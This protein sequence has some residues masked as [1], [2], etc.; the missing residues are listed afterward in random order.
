MR[1]ELD[2][3]LVKRYPEIFK[4]RNEDMTRTAMCWG[5]ECGDGWFDIIN[6]LCFALSEPLRRAIRDLESAT[7]FLGQNELW[8]QERLD[9]AKT[10]VDVARANI[11]VAEQVKEKFGTLRF[12]IDNGN[13]LAYALVDFAEA[14]SETTCE[15]CGNKGTLYPLGWMRTLCREHAV[16]QYGEQ[17]VSDFEKKMKEKEAQALD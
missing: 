8:T 11:P 10:N 17:Q 15:V 6:N 12:Y 13:D 1:E 14:M 5:F 4:H 3:L 7:K 9:A 16:N 2:V